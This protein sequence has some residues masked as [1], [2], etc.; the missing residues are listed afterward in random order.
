MLFRRGRRR[1]QHDGDGG[2]IHGNIF[3]L[4]LIEKMSYS[5]R[6]YIDQLFLI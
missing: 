1:R 2:P 4:Y 5:C 3:V 6:I